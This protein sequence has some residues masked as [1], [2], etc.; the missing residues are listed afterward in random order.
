MYERCRGQAVF[1]RGGSPGRSMPVLLAMESRGK[2]GPKGGM[3]LGTHPL[4]GI[5]C[6]VGAAGLLV[7]HPDTR[8]CDVFHFLA[9]GKAWNELCYESPAGR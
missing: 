5:A 7:G 2:A 6:A 9:H 3:G 1:H 4:L 8:C